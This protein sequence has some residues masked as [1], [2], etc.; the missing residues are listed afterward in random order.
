MNYNRD[1]LISELSGDEGYKKEAYKDSLGN[2]TIGVGHLLGDSPRMTLIY[3]FE[4]EALLVADIKSAEIRLNTY[5]EKWRELSDN[6][7]R[8][9][10][11]MAFNLGTKLF[12]FVKLRAALNAGDFEAA[13]KEMLDSLWATQVGQRA[14]RLAE[15]MKSDKED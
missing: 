9:L 5:F 4:I 1:K 12:H 15:R 11:N 7:Q 2:W 14:N 10:L 6:R 3:P 13:S 8:V